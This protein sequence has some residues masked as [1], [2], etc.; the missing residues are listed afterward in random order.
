MYIIY[1]YT[2]AIM[3]AQSYANLLYPKTTQKREN[4]NNYL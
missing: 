3:L 2:C 1:K 4:N